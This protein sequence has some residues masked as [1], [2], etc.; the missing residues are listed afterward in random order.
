MTINYGNL[1]VDTT[2]KAHLNTELSLHEVEGIRV[3][4]VLVVPITPCASNVFIHLEHEEGY[5]IGRALNTGVAN[6][7]MYEDITHYI[8]YQAKTVMFY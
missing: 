6:D 4:T 2:L 8:L 7:T 3:S 5:R 1:C